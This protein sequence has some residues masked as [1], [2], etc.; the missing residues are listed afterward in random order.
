[1][2]GEQVGVRKGGR[3][4]RWKRARFNFARGPRGPWAPSA[5]NGSQGAGFPAVAPPQSDRL[6]PRPASNTPLLT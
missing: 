4:R 2:S 3:V 1:M 6:D 5:R